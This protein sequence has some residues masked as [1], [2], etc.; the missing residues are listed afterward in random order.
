MSKGYAIYN[1]RKLLLTTH[2][3]EE[4]RDKIYVVLKCEEGIPDQLLFYKITAIKMSLL[5]V[6]LAFIFN[7]F[8]WVLLMKNFKQ[9]GW[10]GIIKQIDDKKGL[11]SI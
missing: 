7:L 9:F 5:S 1:R 11:R 4:G 2:K 3:W 6:F 10:S 8:G